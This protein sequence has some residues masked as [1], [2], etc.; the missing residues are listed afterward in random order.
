[1]TAADDDARPVRRTAPG[2][3]AAPPGGAAADPRV[4]QTIRVESGFGYG[5]VG[6]DLHVFPDR[7]PVYLLGEHPGTAPAPDGAWLLDQ[8]SRMLNARYRLVDFTGRE[9][10]RTELT[11]WRDGPGPRLSATWLHGPGGHGKSRLADE[12]AAESAAA[13]WKVVTATHGPGTVLASA[14][15]SG[16]DL[17]PDGARGLLLVV[18]YA[19]RWP[20]SHLAWLFSNRLLAGALPTRLLL[21]ARSATAWPAVRSTLEDVMAGTRDQELRP[22]GTSGGDPRAR[23]AMFAA[24]RNCFAARYGVPDPAVIA[25]PKDLERPEF[26]LVLAVHMAALV[27]VD[28]HVRGEQAPHDLAGLSAYLLNRERRHWTRLWENRLEGLDFGTPP[29]DMDRVV[30]TAAL[31]GA[32]APEEGGALLAGLGLE[33]PLRLLTDHGACYPPAEPGAVL[34]PLYPDRLAEDFLALSLDGHRVTGYPATPWAAPTART[35]STR[36]PDGALPP[37]VTRGLTFLAAA[38]A[39]GRWPHV[40]GHLEQI[41]RQD[42]SVAVAAGSAA[43][44]ALAETDL[45]AS[46]LAA[47]EACFPEF[48]QLDLDAGIATFT[49]RLVAERLPATADPAERGRLHQSLGFRLGRA[50]RAREA[51]AADEE[52]VRCFRQAAAGTSATAPSRAAD[53]ATGLLHLTQHAYDADAPDRALHAAEEAAALFQDL[54]AADPATHEPGFALALAQV[55]R[56]LAAA[57]YPDRATAPTERAAGIFWRLTATQPGRYETGLALALNNLGTFSWQ[58]RRLPDAVAAQAR[59]I[60]FARRGLAAGPPAGSLLA[61][62]FVLDESGLAQ[63]LGNLSLLLWASR[64]RDEALAALQE[65]LTIA[66]RLATAAPAAHEPV[67]AELASGLATY[68]GRQQRWREAL[69]LAE[70]AAEITAR[71][72]AA[73]PMRYEDDHA[74]ALRQSAEARLGTAGDLT[75]ARRDADASV[76]L[77]RRLAERDPQ[78]GRALEQAEEV[79]ELAWSASS[80]DPVAPKARWTSEDH[81]M[82]LLNQDEVWQDIKDRRHRLDEMPVSYCGNVLRFIRSQADQLIVLLTDGLDVAPEALGLTDRDDATS[83]LDRQPLIVALTRR[84]RGESARP[85]LCHCGYPVAPDWHHEHCYPGIVVD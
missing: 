69:A 70:E 80:A 34:E 43:L 32:L 65:A 78:Y 35:L 39:P 67:L 21:L 55:G 17:R 53:L 6:A 60:E 29:S 59:A 38:A 51:L 26:G 61:R 5:V 48:G 57:G 7:G 1:M 74:K 64:R 19:D 10:E 31:T 63:C 52:A 76:T 22:L 46:V 54:A 24:A 75:A 13:G 18:D 84:A 15:E 4:Q 20:V 14:P 30:F 37:S 58:L 36:G 27:A 28:A 77:Y 49:A 23:P 2:G 83:W 45:P 72:A 25:P 82:N 79:Q 11:A 62:A 50:G 66:R 41:L 71:L 68:L 44:T 42:P 8:P 40:A 12:F 3:G 81:W 85:E 56:G 73:D 33:R 16:A 9:R 47:V